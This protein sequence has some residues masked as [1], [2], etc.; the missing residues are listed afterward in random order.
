MSNIPKTNIALSY[1]LPLHSQHFPPTACTFLI[2][3]I[4]SSKKFFS[5]KS[6]HFLDN[7]T[8]LVYNHANQVI[9]LA[10]S[11]TAIA[12]KR[13]YLCRSDSDSSKGAKTHGIHDRTCCIIIRVIAG[14][15]DSYRRAGDSTHH[16]ERSGCSATRQGCINGDEPGD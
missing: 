15:E 5:K 6:P 8:I 11:V 9:E 3:K 4:A 16:D 14:I 13:L 7:M 12:Q 10:K 2:P 1:H